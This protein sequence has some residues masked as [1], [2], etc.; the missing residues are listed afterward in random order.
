MS[1]RTFTLKKEDWVINEEKTKGVLTFYMP[2]DLASIPNIA[3]SLKVESHFN[4]DIKVKEYQSFNNGNIQSDI[5]SGNAENYYDDEFVTFGMYKLVLTMTTDGTVPVSDYL[6]KNILFEV[7]YDDFNSILLLQSNSENNRIVKFPKLNMFK[8]VVGTF[9]DIVSIIRP[10]FDVVLD[11]FPKVNYVYISK[12]NRYYYI[13]DIT[14]VRTNVYHFKC[15]CDTLMSFYDTILNQDVI[16]TRQ[17]YDF[18]NKIIDNKILSLMEFEYRRF[19][20]VYCQ[21]DFYNTIASRDNICYMVGLSSSAFVDG[22]MLSGGNVTYYACSA[23]A[24]DQL[25]KVAYDTKWYDDI[26]YL[27]ADIGD[28]FYSLKLFLVNIQNLGNYG[29]FVLAHAP[30][31]GMG[32]IKV[33]NLVS[34][35]VFTTHQANGAS[36]QTKYKPWV[37]GGYFY[38]PKDVF[39][40]DNF[41]S[42][43]PYT[44][45]SLYIPLVGEVDFNP[46]GLKSNMVDLIYIVDPIL[47]NSLALLID[48]A[49]FR[50]YRAK[51]YDEKS[52]LF[53]LEHIREIALAV[54]NAHFSIDLPT[55]FSN[56]VEIS[57]NRLLGYISAGAKLASS[58][59]HYGAENTQI[60][61]KD[62]SDEQKAALRKSSDLRL[63]SSFV[64]IAGEVTVNTIRNSSVQF[65]THKAEGE[66]MSWWLNDTPSC[67]VKKYKYIKPDNYEHL[68]G[69]PSTFS[70]KLSKCRGFTKVGSVFLKNLPNATSEEL[71]AIEDSLKE[72][73]LCEDLEN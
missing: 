29:Q 56:N 57:R 4:A 32:N 30:T 7:T 44:E 5:W 72:G 47:D 35:Y 28:V 27:W 23:L 26:R 64:N 54:Y 73:V 31:I 41:L 66:F 39:D 63:G 17:E 6:T 61:V 45:Y 12:F 3:I 70:G 67:R 11:E 10:E 24:V 46:L 33:D 34:E 43:S 60:D 68:L 14:I 58:V 22:M 65:Q 2:V 48:R 25:V 53:D 36:F 50:E 49:D 40:P 9:R 37:S 1:K 18:N 16:V 71:V 69:V 15:R 55:Y 13:D 8:N 38:F 42:Y 20:A 62:I 19:N 51:Y 21:L 52:K 59:L